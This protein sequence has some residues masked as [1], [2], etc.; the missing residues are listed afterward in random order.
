MACQPSDPPPYTISQTTSP[1]GIG[2]GP[3]PSSPAIH[4]D[5][6]P[7]YTQSQLQTNSDLTRG[8]KCLQ[9]AY[10]VGIPF[11]MLGAHH[12]YLN[13]PLFGILY[14]CTLGLFGF[15]WILDLIRMKWLVAQSNLSIRKP[16]YSY[17]KC[18]QDAY[19]LWCGPLGLLGKLQLIIHVQRISVHSGHYNIQG[20]D[21]S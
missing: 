4:P 19:I 2:L 21:W 17:T 7:F 16:K 12:F 5:Q 13:R 3:P 15:G 20:W 6:P 8:P 1:V 10:L 9:T 14:L 18:T 11:G